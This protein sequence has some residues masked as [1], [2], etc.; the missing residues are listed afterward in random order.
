VDASDLLGR[1]ARRGFWTDYQPG[2]RFSREEVGTREFFSEVEAHRYALEPAIREFARFEESKGLQVLD[3][4]CGIATDGLQFAR[5]GARYQ[6]IDFSPTALALARRRFAM[7]TQ[8][9]EFVQ[10]SLTDLP[11]PDG[12]FDLVY[13]N[14]VIHHIPETAR[15]VAEFHRVLRPGGRAVVLVYHRH[16]IN[17]MLNIMV[18]RR[19]LLSLLVV[20]GATTAIARITG[21]SPELLEAHRELLREH[22]LRYVTDAQLFL[23]NNTDGPGNPLSKVYTAPAAR[24]LFQQFSQV[25]TATRYLNLRIYP[26]GEHLQRT[27]LGRRLERRW[28][29]HLWIEAVK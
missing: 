19:L 27:K 16:S 1:E 21:E 26:G 4:G 13:S 15:A 8:P 17:H 12:S 25:E 11:F 7:E 18:V 29:W 23:S 6:G 24:R 5:A 10:G 20:P 3:A 14:G 2:F 22:G 9:G 28:G